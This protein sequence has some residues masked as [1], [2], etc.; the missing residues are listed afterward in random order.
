M[1]GKQKDKERA[2]DVGCKGDEPERPFNVLDNAEPPVCFSI[3]ENNEGVLR[4]GPVWVE[5]ECIN[6]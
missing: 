2:N 1:F 4:L 6:A 5:K 3:T